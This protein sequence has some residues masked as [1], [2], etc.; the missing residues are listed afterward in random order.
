[1][2]TRRERERSWGEKN[3]RVEKG[4]RKK[5]ESGT[6]GLKKREESWRSGL[7]SLVNDNASWWLLLLT[8]KISHL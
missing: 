5:D 1:M 8:F 6:G 2:G 7:C 3:E 4:K